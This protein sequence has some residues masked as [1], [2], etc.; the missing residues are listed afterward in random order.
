MTHSQKRKLVWLCMLM[1][2]SALAELVT[3]GSVVPFLSFA[4][5]PATGA[6]GWAWQQALGWLHSDPVVSATLLFALAYSLA[7]AL[8]IGLLWS[9]HRFSEAFG[10]DLAARVFSRSIR[11]DY[12]THTQRNS[13]DVVSA[14]IKVQVVVLGLFQPLLEGMVSAFIAALIACFM[15]F[16]APMPTLVGGAVAGAVYLAVHIATR[17]KTA[18]NS[19]TLNSMTT[20][21]TKIVAETLGSMRETILGGIH[22]LHEARF[23]AFDKAYRA[24]NRS[25]NIIA[26]LPRHVIEVAGIW[27]MGVF[28]L[29][30]ANTT[31]GLSAVLPTLGAIAVGALRLL[32]LLQSVWR[33]SKM[34]DGHYENL[35]HVVAL[36]EQT[37]EADAQLQTSLASPAPTL[38]DRI[39]FYEVGFRYPGGEW[40]LKDLNLAIAK[41]E[42]VGICGETGSGKSTFLDLLLGLISPENGEIRVDGA[43]LG[44]SNIKAWQNT[45]AHVPQTVFLIDDS[46]AA[47]VVFGLEDESVDFE[48]LRTSLAAAQLSRM[49]EELPAGVNTKVGERGVRLSGG[50]RQRIGIARAIYRAAPILV[51]DEATSSLDAKT[52]A[53]VMDAIA[54]TM[55]T[56]TIISVA[57]RAATLVRCDRIITLEGGRA[58]EQQALRALR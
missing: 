45:L 20:A 7:A 31:S 38:K 22:N 30:A 12:L 27:L 35:L 50:Q 49:I 10:H 37:V 54:A 39:G 4:A 23:N 53:A 5:A 42:H 46:I 52:E 40:A 28:V 11:Q 32:P 3:I 14:I 15:L 34:S 57:H 55:P 48:R 18:S 26:G 43:L 41:G 8:R 29:L 2:V 6:N 9:V 36:A 24:A 51:L 16:I 33:G 1:F 47:N 56:A 17:K 44:P 13:S 19:V 21:R 58:V 25:N